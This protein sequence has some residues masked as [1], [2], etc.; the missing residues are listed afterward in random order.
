MTENLFELQQQ[1]KTPMNF[2]V[3]FLSCI[4]LIIH[5]IMS[6]NIELKYIK[7]KSL[8]YISKSSVNHTLHVVI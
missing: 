4:I 2:K 1:K 6:I 7:W 8:T 5:V 3:K